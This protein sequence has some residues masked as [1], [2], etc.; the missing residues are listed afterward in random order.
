MSS[1]IGLARAATRCATAESGMQFFL[2]AILRGCMALAIVAGLCYTGD[3][4]WARYK[5]QPTQQMKVDRIYAA[6]THWNYVEYS[7]G[8]PLMETCLDALM[9]HFGYTPCWYLR[10]HTIREISP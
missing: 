6:M 10:R 7:V 5:A 1:R 4:L 3:D 9:R 8:A 2:M